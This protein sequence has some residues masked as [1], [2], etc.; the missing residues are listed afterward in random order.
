MALESAALRGQ[1]LAR[2]ILDGAGLVVLVLDAQERIVEVFGRTLELT[3]RRPDELVGC[4]LEDVLGSGEDAPELCRDIEVRLAGHVDGVMRTAAVAIDLTRH[5]LSDAETRARLRQAELMFRQIPGATWTT[6][7]DLRV[8][9]FVGEVEDRVGVPHARIVGMAVQ[10][11]ARTSEPDDPVVEAHRRALRGESSSLRYE[12]RGRWYEVHLEPLLDEDDEITGCI[13]AAIDVTDRKDAEDRA[14][15]KE[16]ELAA[17]Q[18]RNISL[19]EATIESTADGILVVDL[20]GRVVAHNRRFADLWRIPAEIL[21]RGDDR[22]LLAHVVDQLSDPEDFLRCVEDLY[23]RPAAESLDVLHFRDG[24]VFERYSRPQNVGGSIVGRVWSFREVT[25]R[26]R[27]LRHALLLSDASRILTTLDAEK[28]LDGVARLVVP[29]LGDGCTIDQIEDGVAHRTVALGDAATVATVPSA[30]EVLGDVHAG[31]TVVRVVNGVA[32]V[33]APMTALGRVRGAFTLTS[34]SRAGYER[35]ER[36]VLEEVARRSAIVVENSRLYRAAQDQIRAREEFVAVASH[37]IR[38]PIASIRLAV[39]ALRDGLA[40]AGRLIEVIGSEERRLARLVDELLDLGRV[41]SG[42]LQ[43]VL[44]PV[45]L[46]EIVG[47]A[48]ARLD[49]ELDRSG[50]TLTFAQPGPIVGWWDRLRLGQVVANLLTNAI[51]FG[52]GEPIEIRLASD[53]DWAELVVQDHGIGIPAR[54][55]Q[56]VFDPFERAVP[57]RHYGGLGLGLYIVRTIVTALGGTI[58]VASVPGAGSTFTVRLPIQEVA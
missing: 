34:R 41:E 3:G 37:E 21:E 16:A 44:E 58:T 25:D 36:D 20:A 4:A 29:T 19:L 28:A 31:T 55:Q 42:P 11:F 15:A 24:R 56:V 8:T 43:L 57:E 18:Q 51:K 9:R 52:L 27:V 17:A 38:G 50:S 14:R 12:L 54:M 22:E 39:Q 53:D 46:S 49:P 35:A 30:H 40:P 6:D 13:A 10:D 32:Q 2:G 7:L 47:E 5:A 48:I 45:D 33:S 26:E 23:R 1:P